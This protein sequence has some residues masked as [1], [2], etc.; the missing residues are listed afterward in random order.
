[1]AESLDTHPATFVASEL[2]REATHAIAGYD[3]QRWLTVLAWL[4][5]DG[6]ESLWIEWAED[7]TITNPSDGS[8]TVQAKHRTGTISL[9][10]MEIQRIISAAWERPSSVQTLVWTSAA[11]G[12]ERGAPFA[13]PGIIRWA[14]IVDSG[15]PSDAM[16][17]FLLEAKAISDHVKLKIESADDAQF[18][19]MLRQVK[20]VVG[21]ADGAGLRDKACALVEA[22]LK[23]MAIL[24]ASLSR[25]A[26]AALL[27]EAVAQRSIETEVKER[28][29]TRVG[30]DQKLA[31]WHRERLEGAAPEILAKLGANRLALQRSDHTVVRAPKHWS[32]AWFVYTS[33]TIPLLGREPELVEFNRFAA[34][35]APFLWWAIGGAGGLGKSR[36]AQEAMLGL[37]AR[38][39][40]GVARV[41]DLEKLC[42]G[43]PLQTNDM[44]IVVDYAAVNSNSVA[45]FLLRCAQIAST[46]RKI[47][48]VLIDRDPS[49]RK[50]WWRSLFE[51]FSSQ[52]ATFEGFMYATPL[53]LR[54]LLDEG[55]LL[56]DAWLEAAGATV[57]PDSA[58][59]EKI[60]VLCG[61]N[62]LLLGFAAASLARGDT[63]FG[64]ITD[65][66]QGLS[67]REWRKMRDS[68]SSE[69]AL[70]VAL[71]MIVTATFAR[72][73]L[74]EYSDHDQL[75]LYSG[76]SAGVDHMK[77][78]YFRTNNGQSR[79]PTFRDL[80]TFEFPEGPLHDFLSERRCIRQAVGDLVAPH[81]I[82]DAFACA[83]DLLSPGIQI[84]PDLLGEFMMNQ[85]LEAKPSQ[86]RPT[87]APSID[88]AQLRRQIGAAWRI[89][90][91]QT[92]FSLEQMRQHPWSVTGFLR[93]A[94]SLAQSVVQGGSDRAIDEFA[95]CLYNATVSVG[96]ATAD[97]ATRQQ[98]FDS[99]NKLARS[100]PND[101]RVQ[102]RRLK[103]LKQVINLLDG[104]ER[105]AACRMFLTDVLALLPIFADE[106][107]AELHIIDVVVALGKAAIGRLSIDDGVLVLTTLNGVIKAYPSTAEIVSKASALYFSMSVACAGSFVLH[108][109][110]EPAT[111]E[112]GS[113]VLPS[114]TVGV[115]WFV[116]SCI[117]EHSN[118]RVA[119]AKTLVNVS[120][121]MLKFGQP[122]AVEPLV[123]KVLALTAEDRG[124]PEY[125]L[126]ELK[127]LTNL[128]ISA[129]WREDVHVLAIALELATNTAQL[130]INNSDIAEALLQ[131]YSD[132]LVFLHSGGLQIND[133]LFMALISIPWPLDRLSVRQKL[134][135]CLSVD[136][137]ID[138]IK[139]VELAIGE[140]RARNSNPAVADFL[141]AI[142]L[143]FD[144]NQVEDG[145]NGLA[146]YLEGLKRASLGD[147]V[148]LPLATAIAAFW[149]A[150]G[151]APTLASP[152]KRF[153]VV[154][155][156]DSV[157]IGLA[158]DLTEPLRWL[159]FKNAAAN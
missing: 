145:A 62:P 24:N 55:R 117:R 104:P 135:H 64:S 157:Q 26:S 14:E 112:F 138:Q 37:D 113:A 40:S 78:L 99:L 144:P 85:C 29:L 11:A 18:Q 50:H 142:W 136:V 119:A 39:I 126:I 121:A 32:F 115:D 66:L 15:Q 83:H 154:P 91:L 134:F 31:R 33:R 4:S 72:Q 36:L 111:L 129:M 28:R 17:Q 151:R 150:H 90:P 100:C 109:D 82:A 8:I 148:D 47:R 137:S 96:G 5:L 102:I 118:I 13:G 44:M 158:D 156:E 6:E 132:A 146:T 49:D 43:L 122:E 41:A 77:V 108:G 89:S 45:N 155:N 116:A 7:F 152:P 114:L 22:R 65:L 57:R 125:R 93:A 74:Y 84:Q 131:I 23:A 124:P 123:Q 42:E 10:Q 54:P 2:R 153:V 81:T 88:D 128:A 20:W 103:A 97:L 95:R 3:W 52:A 76:Y 16:R 130:A 63:R 133:P 87:L 1:L 19:E 12:L 25:D 75:A 27:F 80:E 60:S 46:E 106:R 53:Y 51:P 48:V 141:Q 139:L 61:G 9:G 92:V 71:D 73:P 98:M 127:A 67:D 110:D 58:T 105:D 86:L 70:L 143:C 94:S 56:L 21:E 101:A 147:L 120:L 69:T 68:T 35:P 79:L 59:W 38:W 149:F 159:L 107:D 30:L 140:A 34:D